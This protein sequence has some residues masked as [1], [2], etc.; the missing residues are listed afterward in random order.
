MQTLKMVALLSLTALSLAGCSVKYKAVGSFDDY[1]EVFVG[2]V[3]H[4][5]L[6]GSAYI[7]AETKNS[8]IKCEGQS[9]VTHIPPLSLGCAGQRGKA[10]LRCTDGRRL[11]ID[12]VAKSCTVGFGEGTDQNGVT[13]RLAFGLDEAAAKEELEKLST[14]VAKNPDLPV[15]RPK[16][17]RKEKGFSTGTGFFVTNDGYMVTNFH[18]IEG[19]KS[20]TVISPAEKKELPA[21]IIQTDPANDIAILKVEAQTAGIPLVSSFT[22]V[23]G[24]EVLTL[25]F[26]LVALQGQE[27]KAT[28][29]RINA[30]SGIQNDIRFVQVDVP[31]QPGNSGGPLLNSRGEVIGVVT[32]TLS[33]IVTLRASGS[34][35][36]N[37]NYAVK[38]DY[39]TPALNAAK[40]DRSK[41]ISP[42]SSKL[43]MAQVVSLRESS[44]MLVVAK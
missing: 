34:L 3:D 9:Y 14:Q 39:I 15:Y 26:P 30:L 41:V 21:T 10:P 33:Q 35:P 32:A 28:F 42:S 17:F 19:A 27:Q 1:N 8:K 11:T 13:F 6:A 43:D 12:W 16:E 20:V 44:V 25:G 29:G 24:E 7:V 4:N 5:L 37:V 31:I 2:D 40:V 23:K 18:V 36:Q 38:I 22:S